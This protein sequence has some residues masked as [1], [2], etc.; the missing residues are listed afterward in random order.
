MPIVRT[1]WAG[2]SLA[3]GQVTLCPAVY[4]IPG[5]VGEWLEIEY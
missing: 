4:R 5:P 2:T 1:D 3:P